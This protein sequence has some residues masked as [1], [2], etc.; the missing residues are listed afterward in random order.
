[1]RQTFAAK[2]GDGRILA[3]YA[4]AVCTPAYGPAILAGE[5]QAVL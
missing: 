2:G 4:L 5:A 3:G 1:M